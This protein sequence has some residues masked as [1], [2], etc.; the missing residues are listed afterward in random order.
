MDG[1]LAPLYDFL[2]QHRLHRFCKLLRDAELEQVIK[3]LG[4]NFRFCLLID[5]SNKFGRW[6][7]R[8]YGKPLWGKFL[9]PIL[10]KCAH[11]AYSI[12]IMLSVR[13]MRQVYQYQK[14][15]TAIISFLIAFGAVH[16]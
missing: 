7:R 6:A 8:S 2:I 14:K 13:P 12:C 1:P 4:G 10:L 3:D 9:N 15:Y 16:M 11:Y 5:T